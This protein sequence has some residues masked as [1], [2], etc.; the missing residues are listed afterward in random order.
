[1]ARHIAFLRAI[2]VGGHTVKMDRL[3]GLFED[4][5]LG[6]VETVIASG[7]VLFDS[8][9]KDSAALERRIERHLEEELGYE[10]ATFIRSP[11]EIVATLAHDAF[12]GSR[13]RTP[14]SLLYIGF[15]KAKPVADVCNALDGCLTSS[16][17]FRIHRREL[18]WSI[19]GRSSDSKFG[20]P[21]LEKMLKARTTLR[22]VT[23]VKRI[24][25]LVS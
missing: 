4:I 24:A 13:Q 5:G 14:E 3:R 12:A 21:L 2:N 20:G 22:N 18:F 9:A 1:M 25:E 8:S 16:D 10:V 17:E 19:N 6:N 11:K 23:T 15:L 7:N